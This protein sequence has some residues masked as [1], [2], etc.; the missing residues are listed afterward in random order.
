VIEDHAKSIFLA[1]PR[2]GARQWPPCWTRPAPAMP[3]CGHGLITPALPSGD[4]QQFMARP[5]ARH[6][7]RR[8]HCARPG[9]VLGSTS[10]WSRLAKGASRRLHGEQQQPV[11]QEVALKILKSGMDTRQ[12][13]ARFE[14]ERQ[15]LALMESSAYRPH[16]GRRRNCLRAALLRHGT[17][18]R[19]PITDFC[20]QSH[21]PVRERL[22]LFVS[23]CQAVQHAHQRGSFTAISNPP[24]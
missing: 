17:G 23:V 9:T 3:S 12:V 7:P 10:C 13:V 21:F 1:A 15:A 6:H 14:A 20:D 18:P 19:H 11:P 4:G 16:P 2:T 24:M 8:A 22:E 5:E